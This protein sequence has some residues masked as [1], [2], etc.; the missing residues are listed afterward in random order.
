MF[1]TSVFNVL[2]VCPSLHVLESRPRLVA[3]CLCGGSAREC[4]S[5]EEGG[6]CGWV[7]GLCV[8]VGKRGMC[9]CVCG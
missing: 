9:V 5:S 3:V 7:G 8:C 2:S 1:R 6:V 4:V